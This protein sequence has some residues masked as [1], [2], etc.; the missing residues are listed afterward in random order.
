MCLQEWV[1]DTYG[2]PVFPVTDNHQTAATMQ[3]ANLV[4]EDVMCRGTDGKLGAYKEIS[5]I[6]ALT[7]YGKITSEQYKDTEKMKK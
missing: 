2:R 6:D 1:V 7:L 4:P 5:G 3:A